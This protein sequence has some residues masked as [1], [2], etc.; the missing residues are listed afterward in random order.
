MSDMYGNDLPPMTP[1]E[2]AAYYPA[3][4]PR[5]SGMAIASLV[6]GL[7]GMVSCCLV[8]P[9]LLGL[10]FGCVALSGIR[11]GEVTGRGLAVAGLVLSTLGLLI[12]G[13]FWLF[14]ALSPD[15]VAL[16]GNLV[17]DS[18]KQKLL[19]MKVLEPG[20]QIELFYTSG[21]F[22]MNEGG[23]VITDTRLV[24]YSKSGPVSSLQ[25]QDI[26]R[27][28]YTPGSRWGADGV[29]S[30]EQDDG[31]IASFTIDGMNES[32]LLFFKT[33]Q[34]RVGHLR[35]DAGKPAPEVKTSAET[36]DF[37]E[38][39]TSPASSG[40]RRYPVGEYNNL[41]ESVTVY[42]LARSGR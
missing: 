19:D 9:S 28:D 30:L 3:P 20:E 1:E 33:L 22:S 29:F 6:L 39:D 11:R 7:V 4:Q 31:K 18:Q 8:L 34:R 42:R 15:N 16:T 27:I 21:T 14:A 40:M 26:A 23:V 37:D 13:G 24:I 38:P 10:V 12:G 5:T 17:S 2:A 32:D 35:K 25:L 36:D 41:G